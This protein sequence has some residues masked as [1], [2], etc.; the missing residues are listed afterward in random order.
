MCDSITKP[1]Q[2]EELST[3]Q[4][5]AVIKLIEKKDKDKNLIKNWSPISLLNG[6]TK[7]IYKVLAEKLKKNLPSLI[8][9]NQT[10]YVK[11]RLISEG[12][13]IMSDI[14]EIFDKLEIKRSLMTLDIQKGFDSISHLFFITSLGKHGFKEDFIKWIQV[15]IQNE[16]SCVINGGT[17]TNYFKL[18]RGTRQGDPV[19][20][21]YFY[22]L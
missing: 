9:K 3:S 1:Y 4:K 10:N 21:I 22:L 16:K 8:S 5:Q 6:D 20:D 14:L 2:N 17:T 13:R 11:R 19:S 12:G 15:L 18:Q 7:I